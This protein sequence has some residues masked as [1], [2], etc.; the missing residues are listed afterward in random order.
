MYDCVMA[1]FLAQLL[2]SP[3]FPFHTFKSSS[4]PGSRLAVDYEPDDEDMMDEEA[5]IEE[6]EGNG[7]HGDHV[8]ELRELREVRSAA[9][10]GKKKFPRYESQRLKASAT[11]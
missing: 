6:E 5:T 10:H 7:G 1:T 4:P 11:A 2:S 8:E 3:S 9:G